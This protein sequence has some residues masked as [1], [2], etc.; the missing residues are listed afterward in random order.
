MMYHD[1]QIEIVHEF[2]QYH[3]ENPYHLPKIL[4]TDT[5][6]QELNLKHGNIIIVN[7]AEFYF[8]Y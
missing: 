3:N 2:N 5:M 6:A 1:I 7:N 8:I 4:T